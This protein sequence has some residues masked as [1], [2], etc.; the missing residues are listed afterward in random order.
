MPGR[1]AARIE[2]ASIRVSTLECS[3]RT[4]RNGCPTAVA[5][6]AAQLDE[7]YAELDRL[8]HLGA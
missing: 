4:Y 6:V 8:E 5:R 1:I 2:A 7:A 3:L